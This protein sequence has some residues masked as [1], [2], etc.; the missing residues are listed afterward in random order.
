VTRYRITHPRL[1][2]TLAAVC[3]ALATGAVAHA[4]QVTFRVGDSPGS[5][6][7]V[8]AFERDGV[9]HVSLGQ[10]VQGLGGRFEAGE[11]GAEIALGNGTASVT[12]GEIE[13]ETPSGAF[14]LNYPVLK[15]S[16]E[17]WVAV[18]DVAPFFS[19]AFRVT[20]RQGDAPAAREPR[21]SELSGLLGTLPAAESV[22]ILDAGHGG[23]DAGIAGQSIVEKDLTLYLTAQLKPA[24]EA[25]GL[26]VG[27]TRVRDEA[28][29][30]LDRVNAAIQ[31][32]GTVFL[33]IHAGASYSG[34][35]SGFEI[36]FPTDSGLDA[37]AAGT[38]AIG[39]AERIRLA[40]ES[41]LLAE[42]L[43]RS[44][45]TATSAPLRGIHAV[46]SPLFDHLPMPGLILEVGVLTNQTEEAVLKDSAFQER[47]IQGIVEGV[48]QYLGQT[49]PLEPVEPAE[50]LETEAP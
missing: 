39:A 49:A 44:L 15:G 1:L 40:R 11:S 8:D 2:R 36:F 50:P 9:L 45:T 12:F 26:K 37:E 43:A 19:R 30:L 46:P 16:R 33:S 13:V 24:L 3:L 48:R 23:N 41:K 18:D 35:A 34:N 6:V 20:P 29:P 17:I 21:D 14:R 7:T 28:I 4:A 25:A 22:V 10:L 47:L 42:A 31:A 32:G 38:R 27:V 5:S